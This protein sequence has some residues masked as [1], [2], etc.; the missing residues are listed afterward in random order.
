MAH[1]LFAVLGLDATPGSF[2][3]SP[4]KSIKGMTGWFFWVGCV[5]SDLVFW[6]GFVALLKL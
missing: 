6:P 1:L 4:C 3:K 2:L 5:A